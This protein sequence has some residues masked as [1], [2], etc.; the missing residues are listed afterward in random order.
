MDRHEMKVDLCPK[1]RS[2]RVTGLDEH[3][4]FVCQECGHTWRGDP[5]PVLPS[6]PPIHGHYRDAVNG[7]GTKEQ[8]GGRA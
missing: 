1:C 4:R 3:V 7:F 2:W 8:E 5:D 6:N